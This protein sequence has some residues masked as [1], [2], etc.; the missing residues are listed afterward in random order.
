MLEAV[1]RRFH[2][3]PGIVFPFA[4]KTQ[5]ELLFRNRPLVYRNS[6]VLVNVSVAVP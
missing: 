5:N 3:L 4:S 2:S 6:P 1:I